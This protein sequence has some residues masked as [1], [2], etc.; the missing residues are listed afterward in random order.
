MLYVGNIERIGTTGDFP[1]SGLELL[2]PESFEVGCGDIV[3]AL[4]ENPFGVYA[5]AAEDGSCI[6]GIPFIGED[7]VT[8][9]PMCKEGDNG[10][11]SKP[12]LL[13]S[14]GMT[15]TGIST[16]LFRSESSVAKH[17]DRLGFRK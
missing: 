4:A 6:C 14:S 2:Y 11:D 1:F 13:C 15:G 9:C 8:A 17:V 10:G 7:V 5:A 12:P 3:L 16:K